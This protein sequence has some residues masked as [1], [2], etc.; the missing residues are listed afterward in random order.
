MVAE[1]SL[2]VP[3]EKWA[4]L[5]SASMAGK[6]ITGGRMQNNGDLI[7]KYLEQVTL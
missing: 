3:L 4:A 2:L 7:V 6:T 1:G 5:F